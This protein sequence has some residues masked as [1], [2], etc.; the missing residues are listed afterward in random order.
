VRTLPRVE[1]RVLDLRKRMRER[2]GPSAPFPYFCQ[3]G[4]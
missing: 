4:W 1:S 3:Q 2:D